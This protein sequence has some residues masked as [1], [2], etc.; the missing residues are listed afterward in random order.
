MELINDKPVHIDFL[1]VLPS[2]IITV[3]VPVHLEGSPAGLLQGGILDHMLHEVQLTVKASA[4]PPSI[5]VNVSALSIGDSIHVSNLDLPAGMTVDMPGDP[6]IA[7]VIMPRVMKA[8]AEAESTE[9]E[10]AKPAE[11]E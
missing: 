5:T 8:A 9:E 7:S 1:R 6:V 2:Q 4:I 3:P 11:G 10:A